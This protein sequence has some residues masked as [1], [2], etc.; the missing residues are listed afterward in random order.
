MNTYIISQLINNLK[1][2]RYLYF[3]FPMSYKAREDTNI[4]HILYKHGDSEV[5]L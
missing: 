5:T 2:D 4:K 1:H 3:K